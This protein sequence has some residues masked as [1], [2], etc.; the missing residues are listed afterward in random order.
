MQ[1]VTPQVGRLLIGAGIVLVGAG[2]IFLFARPLHL[3]SL[4][5][6]ITFSGKGWQAT[7]LIGT[8][9]VLSIVLTLVLNLFLRRR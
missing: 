3:G 8:S 1:D 6:D 7:F 5:G 2:V 4:P 9:L